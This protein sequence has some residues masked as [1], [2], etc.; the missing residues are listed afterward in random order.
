MSLQDRKKNS[1]NSLAQLQK[2]VE[3]L[4]KPYA[5]SGDDRF[6]AP[7]K[8]KSGNGFA[9]IRFLDSPEGE[10]CPWVRIFEHGFR[11]PGGWYIEKS[12][13]TLNQKD[14]CAELN[15]KLWNSGIDA[16]KEIARKQKRQLRYISN[17]LVIKDAACPENED[18]VFLFKYGR[19]IF[20]KIN[21]VLYPEQIDGDDEVKPINPF[22]FWEGANFRLKI[23]TVDGYSNYNSSKFDPPSA[24]FD[25]DDEKIE[26]VYKSE[27]KLNQFIESASF[28]T[29]D[30]LKAR[31]DRV[32][33][34]TE[35]EKTEAASEEKEVEQS[36]LKN[37]TTE[38]EE[39][40]EYDDNIDDE[41]LDA[42]AALVED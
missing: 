3:K 21:E 15:S 37:A 2:E 42:L 27:Y 39:D 19:K 18:K 30:E 9:I 33:G 17:I 26:K 25:G 38:K 31:L 35:S 20:D 29:Y 32:L 41:D 23:K 4:S 14:P 11:G 24:L 12:L 16:D 7:T 40:D 1:K 36:P 13:T 5:K 6:W 22:D 8:D 34:L 10:A 28:K